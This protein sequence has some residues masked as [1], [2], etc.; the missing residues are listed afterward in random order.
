[1]VKD[2]G[3]SLL[4]SGQEDVQLLSI[5]VEL[6]QRLYLLPGGDEGLDFVVEVGGGD[7]LSS[8]LKAL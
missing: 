3:H 8:G 1:M 5:P 4:S 6:H 7:K 2:D